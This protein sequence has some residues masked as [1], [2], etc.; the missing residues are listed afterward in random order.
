VKIKLC[1]SFFLKKKREKKSL[2][3]E[4]HRLAMGLLPW[5]FFFLK[6]N[7]LCGAGALLSFL[8]FPSDLTENLNGEG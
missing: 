4:T 3:I 5:F 1:L 6:K 7:K 8:K 2:A